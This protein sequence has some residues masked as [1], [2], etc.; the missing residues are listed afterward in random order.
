MLNAFLMILSTSYFAW[1]FQTHE[2]T[3]VYPFDAS[4][5]SP[6]VAGEARL[7]ERRITTEDDESLI[8]LRAEPAPGKPT[9]VYFCGN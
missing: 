2:T 5:T 1:Y 7:S 3:A 8:I 9:I 4:Y 6:T